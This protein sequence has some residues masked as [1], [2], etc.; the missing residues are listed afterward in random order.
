MTTY[1]VSEY[2]AL[3]LPTQ[4]ANVRERLL[5]GGEYIQVLG[6]TEFLE[7]YGIYIHVANQ[8]LWV[9]RHFKKVSDET[10][11]ARSYSGFFVN[12]GD[13]MQI[14]SYGRHSMWVDIQVLA[15]KQT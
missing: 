14:R 4:P 2:T 6:K 10:W 15:S 9:N 12:Q 8:D 3:P 7:W 11:E 1:C 13:I 5:E